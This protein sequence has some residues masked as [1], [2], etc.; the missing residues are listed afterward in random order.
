MKLYEITL[1]PQGGLGTPMKGDTLFGQFCWQAAHDDQF[2][3]GGLEQHLASYP[4]KPCAVFSSAWPKLEDQ[5]QTRYAVRRPALPLSQ[6]FPDTSGTC[7]QRLR[8]RKQNKDKKWLLLP[9]DLKP[10]LTRQENYLN[11]VELLARIRAQA[12]LETRRRLRKIDSAKF[13]VTAAQ[14][15][16]TINRLTHTTGAGAFA[17]YTQ[18]M[19]YYYPGTQLAIL[20]LVD[21]GATDIDRVVLALTRIGRYGYGKDASL[22]QGRFRLLGHREMPMP[23]VGAANACYTLAPCVPE[24]GAFSETY[25]LPFVRFGKHGDMLARAANPFKNPVVMADEGAVLLPRDRAAFDR[26]YL[27]RAVTGISKVQTGAVAQGYSLY[28]PLKLEI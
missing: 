12:P 26:P 15:H 9:P 22:G 11:N 3:N 18:E 19:T 6:L 25:F 5:G 20:V 23:E 13:A 17:P 8:K 10:D 16:N 1:E 14:P 21:P 2:L 7:V 4:E 27:G 24:T 28:L